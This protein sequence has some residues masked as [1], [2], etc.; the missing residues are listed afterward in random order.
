MV[1]FSKLMPVRKLMGGN[2]YIEEHELLG[3]K[4]FCHLLY[5]TLQVQ[6]LFCLCHVQWCLCRVVHNTVLWTLFRCWCNWKKHGLRLSKSFSTP[7]K[8]TVSS[9]SLPLSLVR[10]S[11]LKHVRVLP[12][13]SSGEVGGRVFLLLFCGFGGWFCLFKSLGVFSSLRRIL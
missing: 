1:V 7:K 10:C 2:S 9:F 8:R 12:P 13:D 11:S 3:F 4:S 5:L 6:Q